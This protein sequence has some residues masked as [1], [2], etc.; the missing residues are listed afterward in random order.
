MIVKYNE[1]FDKLK[2]RDLSEKIYYELKKGSENKFTNHIWG[3]S[4]P[5]F[6]V[7]IKRCQ[8]HKE[9]T[10]DLYFPVEKYKHQDIYYNISPFSET[11]VR[12]RSHNL[13]CYQIRMI[14]NNV[15]VE[16]GVNIDD[17]LYF[18]YVF[19]NQLKK[20]KDLNHLQISEK[21]NGLG[22]HFDVNNV[23]IHDCQVYFNKIS[24]LKD[25]DFEMI[26]IK[27][28]EFYENIHADFISIIE[29]YAHVF[30]E[31]SGK[32]YQ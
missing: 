5:Y 29:K 8:L 26:G 6:P 1:K 22:K 16:K 2:I 25:Y 14:E 19:L 28:N 32:I 21:F 27:L 7:D 24:N 15:G 30:I 3:E 10:N 13:V 18:G 4:E 12:Q 9:S 31:N 20:H 11:L 23:K 17:G